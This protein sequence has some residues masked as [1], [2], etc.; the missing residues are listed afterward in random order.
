[1]NTA[2]RTIA[3]WETV[4]PPRMIDDLIRLSEVAAKYGRRDLVKAFLPHPSFRL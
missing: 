2:I 4:R 1:M 3:R